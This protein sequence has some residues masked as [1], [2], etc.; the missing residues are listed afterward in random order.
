MIQ[1]DTSNEVSTTFDLGKTNVIKSPIA[2]SAELG[3]GNH[4]I[5]KEIHIQI[6]LSNL[7]K[8]PLTL[9]M[10]VHRSDVFMFAGTNELNIRKELKKYPIP[11]SLE[12][13]QTQNR[14]LSFIANVAGELPFPRIS[15]ECNN[16]LDAVINSY[17]IKALPKAV[18]VLSIKS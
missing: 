12:P 1:S 14:T 7:Q 17:A 3:E 15:I 18:L 16:E 6:S 5:H 9:K 10:T 4:I 8:D 2:I 13:G 11:I